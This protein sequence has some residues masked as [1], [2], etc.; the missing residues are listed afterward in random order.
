MK[1]FSR[2]KQ[3]KINGSKIFETSIDWKR[4]YHSKLTPC[5]F[6]DYIIQCIAATF[7]VMI[8]NG[9]V[10]SDF[11]KSL[12]ISKKKNCEIRFACMAKKV[13]MKSDMIT[14]C[15]A[16]HQPYSNTDLLTV[17]WARLLC[18]YS[19]RYK[20]HLLNKFTNKKI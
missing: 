7:S 10:L 1:N 19:L 12:A 14:F 4:S 3:I 15:K 20:N 18:C 13:F 2:Y 17:L 9:V 6:R 8:F 5:V 16:I 11:P